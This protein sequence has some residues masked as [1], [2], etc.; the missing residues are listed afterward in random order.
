[1][2]VGGRGN[3]PELGL[4]RKLIERGH[5]VDVLG[6]PTIEREARQAGCGFRAWEEAPSCAARTPEAAL[7]RD[8]EQKSIMQSLRD[9]LESFLCGPAARYGRDTLRALDETGADI[10]LSDM[11]LFGPSMAAE[12]R[13]IPRIGLMPNIYI[14]PVKGLPPI[15]SRADAGTGSARLPSRLGPSHHDDPPVQHRNTL[16]QCSARGDEPAADRRSH[17]SSFFISIAFSC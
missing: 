14:L 9:Y 12:S 5:A 4:A 7:V 6:D 3:V 2:H 11:A 15:G 16:T 8:W 1:M 17:R 13:G 10:V